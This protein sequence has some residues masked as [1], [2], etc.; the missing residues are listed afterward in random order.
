MTNRNR[1][2][3]GQTPVSNSAQSA[4]S[5]ETRAR[6]FAA[7]IELLARQIPALASGGSF[8]AVGS[9]FILF[10]QGLPVARIV[11]WLA[12]FVALTAGRVAAY[13]IY[14]SRAQPPESAPRWA[15]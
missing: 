12:V 3:S 13:R 1:A 4:A 9:A 6:L 7:K 15:A 11:A 14:K 10:Q 8:L 2:T 5:S